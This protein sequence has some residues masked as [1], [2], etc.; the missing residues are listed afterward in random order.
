[1]SRVY[2]QI[3]EDEWIPW[4]KG[5]GNRLQCCDCLLVHLLELRVK[6]GQIQTRFFRDNRST[7]ARRRA[8]GITVRQK[9]K[10]KNAK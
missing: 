3:Y 7:A 1:M 2:D 10:P 6:D 9:K 4:P 5:K 8:A